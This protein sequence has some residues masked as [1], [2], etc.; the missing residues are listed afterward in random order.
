M[1][2]VRSCEE[3]G[4]LA[5]WAQDSLAGRARVQRFEPLTYHGPGLVSAP[6]AG[7]VY[8]AVI[9]GQ[10]QIHIVELNATD[11]P[12]RV[13]CSVKLEHVLDDATQFNRH[14]ATCKT[15]LA[16]ARKEMAK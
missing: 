6:L 3:R 12:I 9:G 5:D 8:G 13:L 11:E 2:G 1:S 4:A 10:P 15:C 7:G 16:R 14:D